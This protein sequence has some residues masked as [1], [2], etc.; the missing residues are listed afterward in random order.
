MSHNIYVFMLCSIWIR[1]KWELYWADAEYNEQAFRKATR[2]HSHITVLLVLQLCCYV[3]S[4]SLSPQHGSSPIHVEETACRYGPR[5]WLWIYWISSRE[6][7]TGVV[8][9]VCGWKRDQQLLFIN[10]YPTAFPYGN[11]MVLHFYQQ[12]ESSTTK[13]VH[14]VINKGLKTYV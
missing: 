14:K 12:Q 1:L 13:T 5:E 8:L 9:H 2:V 7:P 4:R 11:G 3:L 10:P 6:Q